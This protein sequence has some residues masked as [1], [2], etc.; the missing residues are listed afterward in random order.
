MNAIRLMPAADLRLKQLCT[1][2]SPPILIPE[3]VNESVITF[4]QIKTR[5]DGRAA[6]FR[7]MDEEARE[8]HVATYG[9]S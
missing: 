3:K 6:A 5:N 7:W 4:I 9:C 2:V 1:A 8:R